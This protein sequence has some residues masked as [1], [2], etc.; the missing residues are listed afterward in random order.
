MSTDSHEE[1]ASLRAEMQSLRDEVSELR[2]Q[3]SSAMGRIDLSMRGRA[4]CPACGGQEILHSTSVYDGP[5]AEGSLALVQASRV[6]DR[7]RGR[8]SVYVCMRCG[9]VEWYADLSD[10]DTSHKQFRVIGS[11]RSD[12]GAP[13]R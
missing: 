1:M 8:F 12:D 10:V 9:L 5:Y 11:G 2:A 13:Y 4:M 3:V 6:L 7:R